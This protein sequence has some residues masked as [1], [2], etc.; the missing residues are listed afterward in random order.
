M[1]KG[2]IPV[3][4]KAE[5]GIFLGERDGRVIYGYKF[6]TKAVHEL[7]DVRYLTSIFP[8]LTL[9]DTYLNPL[10]N[11][12]FTEFEN[13]DENECGDDMDV[14]YE[15]ELNDEIPFNGPVVEEDNLIENVHYGGITFQG[16]I[17]SKS[18]EV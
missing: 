13:E 10:L 7:F 5:P 6:R 3:G 1:R 18:E 8:G 4:H 14:S 15:A 17:E 12:N 16:I 9:K 2:Q 11:L